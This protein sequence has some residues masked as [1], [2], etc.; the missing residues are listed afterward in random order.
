M[1]LRKLAAAMLA[2]VMAGS[3]MLTSC[4]SESSSSKADGS[5]ALADSAADSKGDADNNSG[6]DIPSND[7]GSVNAELTSLE[8]ADLMG[9]GI[10]LGNTME[11]YTHSHGNDDVFPDISENAWGQ[12]LTTQEM[13]DGM[14]AA[15]FD[16]IRIPVAWTN[17][18]SYFED[19]DYTIA[20][21]YLDRVEE[22]VNY[23]LNADMYVIINDHWDGGW[24]GMFGSKTPETAQKAMEM[25]TSMWEQIAERFRDYSD[26][27]I[28]ESA[29]EELGDRL[30]DTDICK[31]SGALNKK[32]CY[33]KTTEINQKF[34]DTIRASGGNNEQRFLLI[35]GY[36]TDIALTCDSK[37]VMP[38][39]TAKDKLLISVHYY[40]PWDYCGTDSVTHW[41]SVQDFDEQNSLLASMKKFTDEGYGVVIGEYGVLP[42]SGGVYKDDIERWT[43]NFLDNCDLYGYCPM[44]W[45]CSDFFVR[46]ELKMKDESLAQLY[47]DR[48]Y[49]AQKDLGEDKIKENAQAEMD[50]EYAA[51]QERANEGISIPAADDKAI[52]WIMY[53]SS[54]YN[55]SYSVGDVYDP[56]AK[57][58]GLI[59]NNVVIDGAGQYSVSL[60][61][62]GC[63]IAKG[64][65]FS[66]LGVS[67]GETLLPGMIITIDEVLVD[68]EKFELLGTPYT[69]SDDAKCTRVNLYNEWISSIP[70]DARTADGDLSDASPTAMQLGKTAMSKLEIKFT[71]TL[72]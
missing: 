1:K 56:T 31:D 72:P 34:V 68:G 33:E 67:N 26:K 29:N 47:L 24:W 71:V 35:A 57:T 18:M 48:S 52:A 25:Y 32:E 16:S 62:S 50:K 43:N 2:A 21:A 5:S 7:D 28:F 9:N 65:A 46:R 51:A 23:A 59:A 3:V 49:A 30:N 42:L 15:G 53:Q 14:K 44:L 10:N 39:D 12:P 58:D 45:D 54:D 19:G 69:S 70:D 60:D 66:A 27:L 55:I 6:A 40:T 13:L 17:A 36:N 8:L 22:I 41:G 38:T 11:A 4:G 61:F 64:V 37:Y 20:P 63:G